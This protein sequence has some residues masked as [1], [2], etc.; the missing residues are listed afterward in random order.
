MQLLYCFRYKVA[1]VDQMETAIGKSMREKEEMGT[2]LGATKGGAKKLPAVRDVA[3][4][5]KV[6][7]RELTAILTAG[8]LVDSEL[9]T[10]ETS[11]YCL[12]V[13]VCRLLCG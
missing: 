1:R 11:T 4:D 7:R 2:G 13:K 12:A 6:I 10:F 3:S 9:L 5:D 8:T